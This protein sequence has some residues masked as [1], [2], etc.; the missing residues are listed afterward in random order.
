MNP[1][2]WSLAVPAVSD[3]L[4]GSGEEGQGAPGA[5]RDRERAEGKASATDGLPHGVNSEVVS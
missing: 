2:A 1:P 5:A 4:S 3:G